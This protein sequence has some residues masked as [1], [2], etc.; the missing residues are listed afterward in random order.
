M[1]STSS[2][3]GRPSTVTTEDVVHAAVTLIDEGGV[4]NLTMRALAAALGVAPM[5][6]YRHVTDKQML[7]ALIPD[8]LLEGVAHEVCRTRTGRVALM[9]VAEGLAAILTAHTGVA[10]L[11]EQPELGPHMRMAAAHVTTL[12]VAEGLSTNEAHAALRA[13]VAQVIGE[14][15]TQH[16]GVRLDGVRLLLE[17]IAGRRGG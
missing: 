7:L 16:D 5:T 6:L 11:F 14:V 1:I 13:V 9:T 8:A 10:Q 17:G 2:R 15:I 3:R 4:E 12:L